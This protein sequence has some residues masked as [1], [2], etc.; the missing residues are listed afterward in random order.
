MNGNVNRRINENLEMEL[1]TAYLQVN[2]LDKQ[3]LFF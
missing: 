3:T 2:G 1:S